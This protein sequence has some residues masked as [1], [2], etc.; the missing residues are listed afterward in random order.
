MPCKY[1]SPNGEPSKLFD[2]LFSVYKERYNGNEEYAERNAV[3]TWLL[4][5]SDKFIEWFGDWETKAAGKNKKLINEALSL[6]IKQPNNPYMIALKNNPADALRSIA[7]QFNSGNPQQVDEAFGSRMVEIA[8][9]LYPNAKIGDSHV[10]LGTVDENGEPALNAFNEFNNGKETR[11]FDSL[12][13]M[14]SSNDRSLAMATD[15]Y[16]NTQRNGSGFFSLY[17][18]DVE[19]LVRSNKNMVVRPDNL[20]SGIYKYDNKFYRVINRGLKKIGE[21]KET[22][23][24]VRNRVIGNENNKQPHINEFFNNKTPMYVYDI[25][26]VKEEESKDLAM[27]AEFQGD[28]KI[29]NINSGFASDTDVFN[30]YISAVS[31]YINRLQD[32]RR[33]SK[34][35]LKKVQEFNERIKE[36]EEIL[37]SLQSNKSVRFL[38]ETGLEQLESVKRYAMNDNANM[39][40]LTEGL[41]ISLAWSEINNVIDLMREGKTDKEL[42]IIEAGR[43]LQTEADAMAAVLRNRQTEKAIAMAREDEIEFGKEYGAWIDENGDLRMRDLDK[44]TVN[45]ISSAY[46]SNPLETLLTVLMRARTNK[47]NEE[48]YEFLKDTDGITK[49]L[50]GKSD[51]DTRFLTEDY[52]MEVEDPETGKITKVKMQGIITEYSRKFYD[53]YNEMRSKAV[54]REIKWKDFY[55]FEKKHFDYKLTPEGRADFERYMESVKPDYVIDVDD[56]GNYVYDEESLADVRKQ[57]DPDIFAEH[58]LKPDENTANRGGQWFTKTPKNIPLN[59]NYEKLTAEQ[60]E[61]HKWFGEQYMSAYV[62]SIFDYRTGQTDID[63][64]LMDFSSTLTE[65]FNNKAKYIGQAGLD[66]MKNSFT[67]VATGTKSKIITRPLT[68]REHIA[69]K[70]RALE[71]FLPEN[72]S[73]INPLEILKK[74]KSTSI[75]YKH[76]REIEEILNVINDKALTATK[77]E[78]NNAGWDINRTSGGQLGTK[79]PLNIARRIDYSVREFLQGT[80][81]DVNTTWSKNVAPGERGLSIGQVFD[82]VNKFTRFRYMALS[83]LSAA[84]NLIMGSI[85]NFTYAASG[86]FFTDK[87]LA[88]A[89]F[90][91]KGAP[92]SFFS[93]NLTIDK[94]DIQTKEA[95]LVAELMYRY[96]ILGDVTEDLTYGESALSRFF[97]LQKGGEFLV[98]GSTCLAQMMHNKIDLA[99]G[100]KGTMLDLYSINKDGRLEFHEEKLSEDSPLRNVENVHAFFDKVKA[101]NDKIHGDYRNPL[102]GKKDVFGRMLFMFRTWLPMAV[103]DR[104]GAE[105]HHHILGAQKGRYRSFLHLWKLAKRN[106]DGKL[107]F[108]KDTA[109]NLVKTFLKL[110]PFAGKAVKLGGNI[111]EVDRR[112]IDMFVRETQMLIM[113]SMATAFIKMSMGDDDDEEAKFMKYLYNQGERIQSELSMYYLPSSYNQILKNIIPM[114]NTLIDAEKVIDAFGNYISDPESDVYKRGFR[115]G[116]SKLSTKFE[117][118]LPVTR[119]IQSTWSVFSQLYDQKNIGK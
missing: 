15:F 50:L 35:N 118:F 61:Y 58:L 53:E 108:Q 22:T 62:N 106:D 21:L 14:Y 82:S 12:S 16:Y 115:K 89:T 44:I 39:T 52:D 41:R 5:R 63:Q 70:F 117:Q 86:E 20:K 24:V 47:S 54:R 92:F 9:E 74:F 2:S 30:K 76:K 34:G 91:L 96:N 113:L 67:V 79:N 59:P 78:Q 49:R 13:Y 25:K 51:A 81:K 36:Q 116:D 43:Q 46:S 102:L 19:Y 111:S 97:A 3:T 60:K 57:Y 99:D 68:G 112:N 28:I 88:K 6:P 71:D 7:E 87:E 64:L 17:S 65:G 114:S 109:L 23:D 4:T 73:K 45:A 95:K 85:N 10:L 100:K 33:R 72:G 1:I 75:S 105:Y 29:H 40:E 8:L 80:G 104:F 27:S 66:F 69:P 83:P 107:E 48:H 37:D 98:Q 77:Q 31:D 90:M 56:E 26:L 11:H 110:I 103:K 94:I 38:I 93:K 119:S 18:S 84:G 101:V 32:E 55:A 42:E